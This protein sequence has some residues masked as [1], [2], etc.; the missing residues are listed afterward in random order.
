M[1]LTVNQIDTTAN[2]YTQTQTHSII[3]LSIVMLRIGN[4]PTSRAHACRVQ[5]HSSL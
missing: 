1:G 3:S 2:I 4:R 5:R